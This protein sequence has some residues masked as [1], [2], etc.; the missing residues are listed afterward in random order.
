MTLAAIQLP[1]V[2]I[3]GRRRRSAFAAAA[4]AL[5]V[6]TAGAN[7]LARPADGER[8]PP[9]VPAVAPQLGTTDGTYE[10]GHSS[11]W[12][13]HPGVHAVVVLAGTLTVYDHD[14]GRQQFGPGQTYVGGDQPHVARNEEADELRF[15]VTYVFDRSSPLGHGRPIVPAPCGGAVL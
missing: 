14:C 9:A 13:V 15:V 2:S 8:P 3:D 4:G 7:L 11:G 12:H 6:A 5:L 10:P 1:Q